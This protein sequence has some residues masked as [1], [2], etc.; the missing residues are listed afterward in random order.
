VRVSRICATTSLTLEASPKAERTRVAILAAAEEQ[1]ARGGYVATRLE[2]IAA[3][4]GL[5]RAALFYH[6]RDKQTLYDAV[7]AVAFSSLV[8]RL[9]EAFAAEGSIAVR[10]ERATEIW[11]DEMIARPTLARLILR[12]AAEAEE[13]AAHDI[14]PGAARLLATAWSLFENGRAKGELNP[15][16]GDPFHAASAVLGS[17]VFYVLGLSAFL[18]NADFAVVAPEQVKEHKQNALQTMRLLLGIRAKPSKASVTTTTSKPSKPAKLTKAV[19]PTAAKASK[20]RR[21]R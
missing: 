15:V 8:T 14:F 19:R 12:H 16:H 9:E 5:K 7:I 3:A 1:F 2:D 17:T 13:H 11:V 10:I 20:H 18:P 6:F 4:V 21:T